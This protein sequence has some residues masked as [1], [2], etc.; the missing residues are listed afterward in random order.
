MKPSIVY[1][2]AQLADRLEEVSALLA[3]E[4]A[5]RDMDSYRKLTRE[6]AELEPVVALYNRFRQTEADLA[7]AQEMLADPDMKELAEEELRTGKRGEVVYPSA[8]EL[9][10]FVEVQIA[11]NISRWGKF[12]LAALLADQAEAQELSLE[13]A[14]KKFTTVD[15]PASAQGWHWHPWLGFGKAR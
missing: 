1:K 8:T 11:E 4:E 10:H 5:T 12:E 7:A 2:L 15:V 3:S 14:G 9:V 13:Q 6:H